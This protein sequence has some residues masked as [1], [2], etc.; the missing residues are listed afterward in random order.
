MRYV[1]IN[2]LISGPARGLGLSRV[3]YGHLK[4]P[5]KIGELI[6]LKY[7]CLR[8]IKWGISVDP[9]F[10]CHFL[11]PFWPRVT[12]GLATS[13]ITMEELMDQS[14]EDTW[15]VKNILESG[16][17][18]FCYGKVASCRS[19]GVVWQLQ[20]PSEEAV[21]DILRR[22]LVLGRFSIREERAALRGGISL[23]LREDIL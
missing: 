11:Q 5:G 12:L 1:Y 6:H 15:K 9:P 7:L 8:G 19:G 4:L 18:I 20:E 3:I 21:R 14:E 16:E 23:R 22:R 17:R 10:G 13:G 2:T